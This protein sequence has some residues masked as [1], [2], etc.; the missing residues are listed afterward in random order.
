MTTVKIN[1]KKYVRQAATSQNGCKDCAGHGKNDGFKLC[2]KLPDCFTRG[3]KRQDFI[4][5][6]IKK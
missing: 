6:E 4:W 2:L 1:G 5:K 3:V